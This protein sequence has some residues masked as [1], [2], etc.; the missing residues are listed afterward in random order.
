MIRKLA[1]AMIVTSLLG[2]PSLYAS[3]SDTAF[4]KSAEAATKKKKKR[5]KN[6]KKD[7]KEDADK[8][9]EAKPKGPESLWL[10][11]ESHQMHALRRKQKTE[12]KLRRRSSARDYKRFPIE[13]SSAQKLAIRKLLK[14]KK[15]LPRRVYLWI[16]FQ[17]LRK[18]AERDRTRLYV[19]RNPEQFK[20]KNPSD[21][22]PEG[23]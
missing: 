14:I 23:P 20:K 21:P 9:D 16:D 1:L 17:S 10:R 7:K 18:D 3:D 6:K 13:L 11:L 5:K 8:A 2:T 19:I 22:K 4:L 15:P 12:K